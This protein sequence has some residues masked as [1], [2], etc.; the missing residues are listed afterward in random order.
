MHIRFGD[1]KLQSLYE[2]TSPPKGYSL[3]VHKAFCDKVRLLQRAASMQDLRNLKSLRYEKLKGPRAGQF[4][5]RL[6]RQLRLIVRPEHD[7]SAIVLVIEE[8]TKHYK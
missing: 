5:L 4:S 3:E 7:N 8:L 6:N 1:K 2:A